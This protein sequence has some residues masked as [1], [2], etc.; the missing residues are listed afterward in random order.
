M[1]GSDFNWKNIAKV[2]FNYLPILFFRLILIGDST[3]GKSSLLKYFT[4]GRFA[5]VIE[6]CL[7]SIFGVID[8]MKVTVTKHHVRCC[9]MSSIAKELLMNHHLHDGLD[10]GTQHRHDSQ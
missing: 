6:C 4:D 3:V 1:G 9:M 5:E 7:L 8:S 10:A 2:F